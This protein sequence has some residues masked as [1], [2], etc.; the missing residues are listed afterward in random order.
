MVATITASQET[1]SAGFTITDRRSFVVL[2]WEIDT[3]TY[4]QQTAGFIKSMMAASDDFTE[5]EWTE[6]EADQNAIDEAGEF[7]FSLNRYVFCA[8]KMA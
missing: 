6:W 5:K 2:N 1:L 3:D 4:A 8:T 7:M